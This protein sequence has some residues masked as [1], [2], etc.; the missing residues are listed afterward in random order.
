M[1]LPI[2]LDQ[3]NQ[4]TWNSRD[5][6]REFTMEKTWSDPGE[7]AAFSWVAD[8]CRD[9]PLLDIGIG[10]GRT[11]P[12]MH[13]I[14]HDYVGIDYTK[15]LLDMSRARYP[16][17][18]LRLMD[19]RDLSAFPD[20]RF[21]LTTFSWNGIDCVDY[22]DR[23]RILREMMRVTR[24]GGLVF[25]STHNREGPGF[26]ESP[27]KLL[28]RLT[29]NPLRFGWR[30]WRA[31]RVLPLATYNYWHHKKLHRDFDGYSIK[32]AAAHFFGIVI[33]YTT[34]RAQRRQLAS[35]GYTIDA[36]FGSCEGNRISADAE[37]SDAWWFHFIA[38]KPLA[39]PRKVI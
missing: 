38:R 15:K 21:A 13:Q 37:T 33:V 34:L 14:S 16:G 31:A 9:Q 36:V 19:A 11:I 1:N 28:P 10:A 35:L 12:L 2:T 25:F 29:A 39:A 22:A 27:W 32:T 24:P 7:A 3:V 6:T 20:D 26:T 23:E 18:D 5:A 17:V 8:E 30:C 4:R